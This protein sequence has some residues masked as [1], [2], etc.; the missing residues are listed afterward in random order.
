MVAHYV[1]INCKDEVRYLREPRVRHRYLII[2]AVATC[3][4][5]TICSTLQW[6]VSVL[7]PFVFSRIFFSVKHSIF[8]EMLEVFLAHHFL[9]LVAALPF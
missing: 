6:V 4:W 1:E 7:F 3:A 2:Y 5:T 8:R 9:N